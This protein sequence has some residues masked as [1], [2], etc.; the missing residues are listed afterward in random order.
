MSYTLGC[1]EPLFLSGF[2]LDVFP[3]HHIVTRTSGKAMIT[4]RT[5]WTGCRWLGL[6]LVRATM[7]FVNVFPPTLDLLAVSG[8]DVDQEADGE[9]K[10]DFEKGWI[11]FHKCFGYY[12]AQQ[13][14]ILPQITIN[15]TLF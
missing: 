12:L 15:P 4:S 2:A 9:K 13:A 6:E 3:G 10:N 14:D 7:L 5:E 1:V 11:D 8:P